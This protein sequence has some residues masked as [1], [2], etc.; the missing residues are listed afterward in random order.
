MSMPPPPPP[1]PGMTPPPPPTTSNQPNP[2]SPGPVA[3]PEPVEDREAVT[4]AD[5]AQRLQRPDSISTFGAKKVAEQWIETA[6]ELEGDL[7]RARKA[8]HEF[9]I[10]DVEERVRRL[11]SLDTAIATAATELETLRAQISQ[12][13][14][15][16]VTV[17]QSAEMQELGLYDFEHPAE[18]SA[19]LADELAR[20]RSE[21]KALNKPGSAISATSNFT[22]NNSKA[23]GDKMVRDYS[24]L[25]LRAYNAEAEN[26]V[27]TVKAGNLHTAQARLD[28]A[29]EQ[30]AKTGKMLDIHVVGRFHRLRLRELELAARH[31]Q[32]LKEEREAERERKAQLREER[33]VQ[34]EIRKEQERLQK[35]RTHY[36]N[37]IAALEAK[38]DLDAAARLQADL[39]DVDR[40]I[41]D[42]D[43]RAANIRAGYVYVISNLGAFGPDMVK[44]GMT[45]RLEPMD[46]IRE[47]SDASV[48]FHFDVHALFFSNDAVGIEAMLHQTF[49]A[50]RV[51]KVNLRRE[52]FHVRPDDVLATL[53]THDVE[54]I[55]FTSE[56]RAE[57]FRTSWPDHTKASA[58]AR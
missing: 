2:P 46:R 36:L 14:V 28:K 42:V 45:R 31:L 13:Q 32:R 23:Q 24:R 12:A 40:A 29:V 15:D 22:F 51:N 4:A 58:T 44:I 49:A 8:L 34:D 16:L 20:L 43:Y 33:R 1:G 19:Q 17:R 48:P 26:C 52:F 5:P 10:A 53:R 37:S 47:L 18:T 35:E 56:H 7:L 27:K 55:E 57:E 3:P 50:Q 41:A 39:A 21:I 38:G 9:G 6:L 54:V 30:I 11:E 25:M